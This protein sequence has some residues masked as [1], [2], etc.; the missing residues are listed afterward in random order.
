MT[1]ERKGKPIPKFKSDAEEAAFWFKNRRRLGDY[2]DLS[3]LEPVEVVEP[4]RSLV[5][6]HVFTVRLDDLEYG[7]FQAEARASGVP[8][9]ALMRGQG[10][11]FARKWHL[12]PGTSGS[13]R[14]RS[15]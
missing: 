2:F 8:V 15:A 12:R 4:V 1:A 6:R 10:R 5:R 7:G 11:A 14:R 13:R 3:R 9:V